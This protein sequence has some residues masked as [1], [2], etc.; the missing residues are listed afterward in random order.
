[1]S[2]VEIFSILGIGVIVFAST[3]ID[4]IVLLSV[5]FADNHLRPRSVVL[6]QF[7]GMGAI[8][9]A[10]SI[11]AF[12]SLA[13]PK[14]W[15]AGL[16]VIPL[17]LGLWKL[18]SAR[19]STGS[20]EDQDRLH[21]QE[22]EVEQRTHSQVLAVALVTVANGGDNLGAYIPLFA[23]QPSAIPIYA[24]L[25]AIMTGVWCFLGYVLVNNPLLGKPVLRC[26]HVVL[27]YVLIGLGI[28]ILAGARVLFVP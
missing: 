27:P 18:R 10:S 19:R 20:A 15:N 8:V 24:A 3:N 22:L 26:G 21:Q 9:L 1:V 4:D 11:G 14:G 2:F 16:G 5:F 17:A 28:Y 23:K 7:A 13:V 25:F 12:A 6:G